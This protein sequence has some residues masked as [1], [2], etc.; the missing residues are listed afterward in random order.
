MTI[1][2]SSQMSNPILAPR[3]DASDL[4]V[5]DRAT[6]AMQAL[7]QSPVQPRIELARAEVRD[8]RVVITPEA[9]DHPAV[10]VPNNV[11]ASGFSP[12]ILHHDYVVVTRAPA[13]LRGP[14]G[15]RA[16]S[17]ALRSNPTPG[18][19]QPASPAGTR[20]DVGDLTPF[21]NDDNFVR[22]FTIPST[23]PRRSDIMVNYTIRGEHA[24][25]EGFVMRYARLND[26]GSIDLISYGEGNAWLQNRALEPIWRPV[27]DRVWTENAHEI[28][29]QAQSR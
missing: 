28:F 27:V 5:F 21:D 25:H 1:H 10:D 7:E 13:E 23:D 16:I 22:S 19:D 2:L 12:G 15:L 14:E 8:G 3:S 29:R 9:R 18:R 11:G 24:M 26:D 17:D 6:A 20:N 4:A